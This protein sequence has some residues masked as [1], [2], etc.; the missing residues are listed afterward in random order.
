M[1]DNLI[2][3]QFLHLLTST[4]SIIF[5]HPPFLSYTKREKQFI[6]TLTRKVIKLS[7]PM[8]THIII[9]F[10]F[11]SSFTRL[12]W[13]CTNVCFSINLKIVLHTNVSFIFFNEITLECKL[14]SVY[15]LNKYF[16]PNYHLSFTAA[17][18]ERGDNV[19]QVSE[20]KKHKLPISTA[21]L[22]KVYKIRS[23][24]IT[25]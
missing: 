15:S 12:H 8:C 13:M 1:K 21:T 22:K 16:L 11:F 5:I 18:V 23:F 3:I 10:P 9:S 14:V 17:S 6:L 24:F 4:A 7:T 19:M 20:R 25:S 2:N